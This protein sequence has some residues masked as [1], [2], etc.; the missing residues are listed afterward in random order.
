MVRT[1]AAAIGA[2]GS[3]GGGGG[4][5][6]LAWPPWPWCEDGPERE[7]RAL[8]ARREATR[9]TRVA[10][11]MAI[12]GAINWKLLRRRQLARFLL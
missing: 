1:S 8:G 10:V 12:V 5:E 4:G 2:A 9:K 3:G 7:P 11:V 6:C